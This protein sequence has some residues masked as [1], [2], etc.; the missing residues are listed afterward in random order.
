[1]KVNL[2]A[3]EI[4]VRREF[5]LLLANCTR[6]DK[7]GDKALIR[8]AFKLAFDAHKE[9]ARKSGELYIL[10]PLA[11]ARIVNQEIGLG[12]KS[13][14]C[15]LLH[16]VVEDTDYTIEDIERFLALRSHPSSTD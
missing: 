1:M 6:C 7:K 3:E 2:N 14:I 8:K 9:C 15:S 13:I 5:N 11:V 4:E 12:A 16:D 10:H